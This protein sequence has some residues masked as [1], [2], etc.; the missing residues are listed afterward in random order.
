MKDFSQ[1]GEQRLILDYFK[2]HVGFFLSIGEND[3]ETLSN[4]R[5][6]A[7]KN[8]SGVCV[9]P[10]PIAYAKLAQLY[11]QED[12]IWTVNAA[13]VETDGPIEFYDSGTH[14]NKGDT[15]LLSTTRPSEMD[16]WKKSGEK[17]EKTTV[18]GIT[19]ATLINE[20]GCDKFDFITID[21]EGVDWEVLRQIDL[22]A[23][24]CR[25]LCVETNSKEDDKFIRYCVGHGM[26][27]KHKNHENL[28]FCR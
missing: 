12:T 24:G 15:S 14:L 23:V 16:R 27:L 25:M 21:C 20:T 9:E 19:I 13:I 17:F 5:A 8:W 28:V 4:V 1:S 2:N 6:L 18:R 26:R 7:L 22:T 3:G 11:K 10:A